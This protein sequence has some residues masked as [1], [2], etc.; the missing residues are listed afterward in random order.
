VVKIADFGF[1]R[2]LEK[3]MKRP[4]TPIVV[5]LWYRSP[6]ILMGDRNYNFKA[7]IWSAG[8]VMIEILTK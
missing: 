2:Y 1:A 7:D 5:T 6:E 8:V 3:V 4:L